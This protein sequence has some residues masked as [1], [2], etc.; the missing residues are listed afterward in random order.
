MAV[1]PIPAPNADN[2]YAAGSGFGSL[3]YQKLIVDRLNRTW[4]IAI[5]P[6]LLQPKIEETDNDVTITLPPAS[7]L[8]AYPTDLN[9]YS[10]S[11]SVTEGP[12]WQIV[13]NC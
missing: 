5:D 2:L 1:S 9:T 12:Y 10:L 8:P 3:A 11:Y 13:G 7:I 6:N 4:K